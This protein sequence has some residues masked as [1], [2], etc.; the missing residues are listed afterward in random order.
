M[1]QNWN[2]S[3]MQSRGQATSLA[4][5]RTMLATAAVELELLKA[6][7]A[8][9]SVVREVEAEGTGDSRVQYAHHGLRVKDKSSSAETCGSSTD[10]SISDAPSFDADIMSRISA[11]MRDPLKSAALKQREVQV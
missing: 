2:D 8:K 11:I 5:R 3:E 10:I 7:S 4:L 6:C 9:H 1:N